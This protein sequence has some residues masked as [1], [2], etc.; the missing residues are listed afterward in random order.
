MPVPKPTSIALQVNVYP[1]FTF[2]TFMQKVQ[3]HI[4]FAKLQRKVKKMIDFSDLKKLKSL[5]NIM[6]M[7]NHLVRKP[8]LPPMSAQIVKSIHNGANKHKYP[9]EVT[10]AEKIVAKKTLIYR[11]AYQIV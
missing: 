4:Y 11:S 9:I 7:P 1:I 8:V 3:A 10:Y 5:G 2:I 6:S